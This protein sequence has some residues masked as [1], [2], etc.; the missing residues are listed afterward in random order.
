MHTTPS[1]SNSQRAMVCGILFVALILRLGWGLSR[2]ASDR[3]LAALPD[4]VEYLTIARYVLHGHGFSFVDPRFHDRVFAFR[5][6]GYPFFL[7]AYGGDVR[8]VRAVQA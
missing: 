3:E 1:P 6:P 2:P 5:M 4:Q 8:R 7:A